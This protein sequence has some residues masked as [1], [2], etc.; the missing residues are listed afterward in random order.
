MLSHEMVTMDLSKTS[1][2][3]YFNNCDPFPTSHLAEY[4]SDEQYKSMNSSKE[5]SFLEFPVSYKT[6]FKA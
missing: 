6:N 3:K 5:K 2:H 4:L 1:Q